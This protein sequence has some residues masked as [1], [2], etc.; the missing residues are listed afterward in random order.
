MEFEFD[1][2]MD[3]LLRQA[4][5][6]GEIE[7]TAESG[8]HIDADEI[9][10]F[11]EN[12]LPKMSRNRVIK[13]LAGCDTCRTVLAN[14]IVLNSEAETETASSGIGLSE[15][16]VIASTN[17]PWFKRLF[18]TQN[19]AYGLGALVLLFVGMLGYLVVPD[20]LNPVT[21]VA[22]VSEND[23]AANTNSLGEINPV[24]STASVNSNSSDT[25]S[26]N[27]SDPDVYS[28]RDSDL[29]PGETKEEQKSDENIPSRT[30]NAK[31]LKDGSPRDKADVISNDLDKTSQKKQPLVVR[32]RR[33]KRLAAAD[34]ANDNYRSKEIDDVRK[35][36]NEA[37]A[38]I[39]SLKPKSAPPPPSPAKLSKNK[40]T[41]PSAAGRAQGRKAKNN[42]KEKGVLNA[43]VAAEKK[44]ESDAAPTR[45]ISGKTFTQRNQVWYDSAYRGQKT[46]KIRRATGGY[47]KLDM[48]LRTIA[49]KLKG[50]VV[51]VWKSKA[52]RIQ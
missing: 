33:G 17:V 41:K 31:D 51:V 3:A 8:L 4:T 38:R 32:N 9:S 10:V 29:S 25:S 27:D 23:Q 49:N 52:Y 46:T 13:H 26:N 5:R 30:D 16:D 47:R 39:T 20:L 18:V 36:A 14:L 6:S 12:A 19:L 1:K 35:E 24:A 28:N 22:Q 21:D 7:L 45:K 40:V 44:T 11:A 34:R 48:G 15:T 50:T 2:E 37:E 43:G 42:R